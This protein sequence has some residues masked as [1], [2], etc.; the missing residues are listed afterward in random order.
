MGDNARLHVFHDAHHVVH[1][2]VGECVGDNVLHQTLFYD[3][4]VYGSRRCLA[5][6]HNK[7][8]RTKE[9]PAE[10]SYHDDENI[11]EFTTVDLSKDG[12]ACCAAWFAVVVGPEVLLLWT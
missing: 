10:I 5:I 6:C 12:L 11:G 9:N 7:S 3:G 4:I 8:A 1:H 2:G